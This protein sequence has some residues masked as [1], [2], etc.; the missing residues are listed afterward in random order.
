MADQGLERFRAAMLRVFH[1]HF[2]GA[3]EGKRPRIV[4]EKA[5]A[6]SHYPRA[7]NGSPNR[8]GTVES[9]EARSVRDSRRIVSSP[10]SRLGYREV[11][12][13]TTSQTT[14]EFISSGRMQSVATVLEPV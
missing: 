9:L 11:N 12:M 3:K 2:F 8:L 10:Y 13:I 5:E 7:M 14:W 6:P 1:R 4:P